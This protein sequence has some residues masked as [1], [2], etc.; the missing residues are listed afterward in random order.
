MISTC[1]ACGV[2][3][4]PLRSP[5]RIVASRVVSYCA[6]CG[7]N[8][9][10]AMARAWRAATED[11]LA[12]EAFT[13]EDDDARDADPLGRIA[14]FTHP[15][16]VPTLVATGAIAVGMLLWT[17]FAPSDSKRPLLNRLSAH[18]E[19]ASALPA[20]HLGE[21][22]R[23]L[24]GL[25]SPSSMVHPLPGA[26]LLLPTEPIRRFGAGR[27]GLGKARGCGQGHCG[28][29]I[30]EHV[31]APVVSVADGVVSKVIRYD[32]FNGGLYV[33][34][35][36]A[37][38]TST[39][40]FHLN[41]IRADLKPGVTV[42]AGEVIAQLGRSGI[43]N[44]PAHLHFALAIREGEH[45]HYVDPEP[46]LRNAVLIAQPTAGDA[47]DMIGNEGPSIE[48]LAA[49]RSAAREAGANLGAETPGIA[50]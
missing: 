35:D 48:R 12:G 19:A 33:R 27:E 45:D 31:G 4:D 50:D 23:Q 25:L 6:G 5:A 47:S 9:E 10:A 49:D 37:D 20:R 13:V 41:A 2:P 30:G 39:F 8:P 46:Y 29:D 40:Y 32:N 14:R 11:G 34:V 18:A 26:N 16:K 21:H 24:P 7:T 38:D 1:H 17:A 22:V 28:V 36:H 3:V 43:L 42:R 44:S 15:R